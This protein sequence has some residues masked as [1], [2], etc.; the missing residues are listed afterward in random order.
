ML[1]NRSPTLPKIV[2][3]GLDKFIRETPGGKQTLR[4]IS[5]Y[6]M[7]PYAAAGFVVGWLLARKKT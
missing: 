4:Q 3:D 5:I 1:Q 6:A 2:S 7:L